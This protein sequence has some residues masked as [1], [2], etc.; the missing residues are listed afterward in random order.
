MVC[1]G[2]LR[3]IAIDSVTVKR[4]LL[5]AAAVWNLFTGNLGVDEL[6]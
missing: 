5:L 3:S 4:M 1:G 6:Q 2:H